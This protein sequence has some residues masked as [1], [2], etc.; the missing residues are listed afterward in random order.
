MKLRLR[1]L[2][3]P[4]QFVVAAVVGIATFAVVANATQA[5]ELGR[6]PLVTRLLRLE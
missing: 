4:A 2:T 6:V 1:N 3:R 5:I